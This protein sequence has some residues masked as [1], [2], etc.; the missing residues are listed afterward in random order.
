MTG[1]WR[2]HLA[3]LPGFRLIR[4]GQ[5]GLVLNTCYAPL[6]YFYYMPAVLFR[7]DITAAIC[8]AAALALAAFVIPMILVIRHGRRGTWDGYASWLLILGGFQLTGMGCLA[9]SAFNIHADAPAALFSSLSVLCLARERDG[10]VSDRA[11][12]GSV[13]F[14]VAATWTKQTYAAVT[15]FPLLVAVLDKRSW[16]RCVA[17]A[18]WAP[19]FCTCWCFRFLHCGAARR[20]CWATW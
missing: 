1:G 6:S 9:Y 14:A 15:V 11:L 8:C 13:A 4:R 3:F 5:H 12:F 10:K 17:L 18:A 2:L 7:H 19:F 16:S 20:P